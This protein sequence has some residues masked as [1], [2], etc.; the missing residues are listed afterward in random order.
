MNTWTAQ[1]VVAIVAAD[2]KWS[3]AIAPSQSPRCDTCHCLKPDG[4]MIS[5]L[6]E[7]IAGVS[8]HPH[9]VPALKIR[10][11]SA[12]VVW[13]GS[14][15]IPGFGGKPII[16]KWLQ[17]FVQTPPQRQHHLSMAVIAAPWKTASYPARVGHST[18]RILIFEPIQLS[19]RQGHFQG[20]KRERSWT[21]YTSIRISSPT[22]W[23]SKCLCDHNRTHKNQSF[24][25]G[26]FFQ[27]TKPFLTG[28]KG[29]ASWE[30]PWCS[31]RS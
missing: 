19:N 30:F 16:G 10:I 17:L 6:W 11:T 14:L 28:T 29:S 1:P 21:I 9:L 13:R 25:P 12:G 27:G 20:P 8:S 5:T 26:N 24:P 15:R 31:R 3:A 4:P 18:S 7:N 22:L 2:M 23:Y